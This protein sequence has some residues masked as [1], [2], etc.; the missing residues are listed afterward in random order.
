MRERKC[1]DLG[2][3]LEP[4]PNF[5]DKSLAKVMR[6]LIICE[7][8]LFDSYVIDGGFKSDGKKPVCYRISLPVGEKEKFEELSGYKLADTESVIFGQGAYCSN[9]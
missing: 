4:Y 8:Y 2:E 1:W 7:G 3:N 6:A 5:G 9:E